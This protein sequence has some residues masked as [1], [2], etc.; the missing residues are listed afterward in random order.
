MI[1]RALSSLLVITLVTALSTTAF[2]A[3]FTPSVESKPAPEIETQTG[4]DGE[5]YA[6][7]IYDEVGKEVAGVPFGDIFVTPISA[8]SKA[9]LPE[10]KTMLESAYDQIKSA[11]QLTDLNAELESIIQEKSVE[12]EIDELAVRDLFDVT[13]TG[14]YEE[15][16]S[17]EGNSI[18][19][20]F[21]LSAD[22]EA[23]VTVLVYC[24]EGTTWK[25]VPDDHIIRHSD[26]TVDI[27]FDELCAIAFVFDVGQL[28]VDPNAPYSPQ[29][30]EPV[31]YTVFWCIGGAIAA[32]AL[33]CIVRK[34][35][36]IQ[37][38]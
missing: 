22:P 1:K 18:T 24:G 34:R 2:A 15:Y 23:L 11:E 10:I 16:L 5:E 3:G 21:N 35:L 13:V 26:G 17:Q 27:I 9:P 25:I 19:I 37:T 4:S 33:V 14:I 29:T 8:V 36:D 31:I 28:K 38:K 6:G 20:N 12:L 7:I 32:F 30:G